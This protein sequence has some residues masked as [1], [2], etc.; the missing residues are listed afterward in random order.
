MHRLLTLI[1]TYCL[2]ITAAYSANAQIAPDRSL[3]NNTVVSDELEITGGTAVGENLFHSFSEFSVDTG[4]TVF[5]N[6]DLAI[7]NI[8][9]RVTGST[10]SNIDGLLRA[11]GTA[12]LFLINPN[13]IVFGENAVLDLGGSFISSTADSIR[14]ADGSEFSATNPDNSLLT[15]NIPV[16]LQY[17]NNPGDITLQGSGNN[18]SIDPET[19]TV[20]RS[21]RPVGLEITNG[22]TLALLGGNVF[23]PGGNLTVAEGRIAVGAVSDGLIELTPD[24]LGWS[25]NLDQTNSQQNIEL[26]QAASIDVS[27]NSGGEVDLQ[28]GEIEIAD[29]SA[30]LADVL[31][32][33]LGR[34]LAISATKNVELRGVAIDN[35]FPTRL[36][37]DVDLDATGNGGELLINTESLLINDGAQVTSGTFG[38]G[39]AGNLTVKASEIEVVGGTENGEPSGLFTQSDVGDT[40]NGGDLNIET[41]SLLVKQ[42][43]VITTTTFGLGD[44]GNLT[45]KASE[46]EILGTSNL[47]SGFFVSTE[48]A[49]NGGNLSIETDNLLVAQG[50]EISTF[51]FGSGNSGNLNVI[52]SEIELNGGAAGVGI[53]G[54]FANAQP[55]SSGNSGNLTIETDNLLV[56]NGAQIVASTDSG[57]NAGTINIKSQAVNLTGT[58][59]GGSPSGISAAAVG[60]EGAGGNIE[61]ATEDLNITD[62]AQIT[63]STSG[64]G[65][66]GDIEIVAEDSVTLQG[67]SAVG[68]SGLFANALLGDASGGNLTVQTNS[69][70]VLDGATISVSNF[71]SNDRSSFPP[72]QGAAGNLTIIATEK[73]LLDEGATITADTFTGDRGNLNFLTDLLVLR[74]G[75]Q[76]TTNAQETATGGNITIDASDGFL[77][78]FPQENSDIT[79][80]AVF[81]DGGKVNIDV[82][83]IFGIEPR[84]NL[85][86][87]SDI[88]TSSE[89]GIAGNVILLTQDLN[90]GADLSKLPS[91]PNPPQLAQGCQAE[92]SQDSS[93]FV[94]IGQGGL[95]PQADA[96]LSSDD[97]I[98]DVQLPAEWSGSNAKIT[99]AQGWIVNQQGK[100][101]LVAE[102]QKSLLHSCKLN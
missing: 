83:Q 91:A 5:F 26:S 57:G 92:T 47:E 64:S 23:V 93:S 2:L 16:G 77:V 45:V 37:T 29:G 15:V 67:Q 28:G 69:L 14:F 80:N 35:S 40:G 12:D 20:D 3:P 102:I 30:V 17:G 44:A 89:F 87:L 97:I 39:D 99:E 72:G 31:G 66:G 48:A 56:N 33:G 24:A 76:I 79:A 65:G 71:P 8:I 54:L 59:F 95:N 75:S 9:S 94:N 58:S 51:T 22:N 100:L 41:N 74:R 82:L 6:N 68:R 98:G 46:I 32:D 18:L 42:G 70:S 36:S 86:P 60:S 84:A 43:A 62:G 52:A 73:I 34:V 11:N 27:G 13:G 63:T 19:L 96:A 53:S 81:G 7:R 21:D 4:A 88:T 78:A 10:I 90:P 61:I 38:S 50:G 55:E 85:T 101:E 25:F 49:G 1:A